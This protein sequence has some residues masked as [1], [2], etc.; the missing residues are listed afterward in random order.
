MPW[1]C[2]GTLAGA[3]VDTD[4]ASA[5]SAWMATLSTSTRRLWS[6]LTG[7]GDLQARPSRS[8]GLGRLQ[9]HLGPAAAAAVEGLVGLDRV[10]RL[11]DP[12][13]SATSSSRMSPMPWKTTAFMG[14]LPGGWGVGPGVNGR[15]PDG[16]RAGLLAVVRR[17]DGRPTGRRE[18][19]QGG[20]QPIPMHSTATAFQPPVQPWSRP[21]RSG[22]AA[23]RR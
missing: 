7:G 4:G 15:H 21:A 18:A 2:T 6:V 1:P 20:T 12:L 9:L 17:A 13:G 23:V 14:G 5:T 22:P 8:G 3:S 10:G 16:F 19:A 11:L